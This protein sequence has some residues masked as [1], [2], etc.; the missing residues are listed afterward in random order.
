MQNV[1]LY[2]L[3]A[4]LAFAALFALWP[5]PGV[6][7]AQTAAGLQGV[8]LNLY[9]SRDPDAVWSFDAAH[10]SSD[11]LTGIT[12]LS[13]LSAGQ[14]TLRD[15]DAA[16]AYT[17]RQHL[18]AT[19]STPSLTIDAQDNLLTPRARLRLVQQCADIDLTGTAGQP[20]RIE[21]GAGFSAAQAVVDSPYL[22]GHLSNLRMDFQFNILA[23]GQDSNVGAPLDATEKCRNGVVVPLT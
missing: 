2:A 9:P 17:G 11:T 8:H 4:L 19:L 16:G 6:G 1:G 7:R 18:D 21:Q 10:V 20:V 3:L 13:G 22:T 12:E 15:K 23:A 5:S 14:R